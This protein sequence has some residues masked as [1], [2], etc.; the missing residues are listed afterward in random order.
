MS[1]TESTQT[2]DDVSYIVSSTYRTAVCGRLAEGAATPSTIA[3][4]TDLELAHASRAL[5][6][7]RG[8]GIVRLLVSDSRTKGRVYGMTDTGQHAHTLAEDQGMV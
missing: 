1:D 8:R 4:D 5:K 3:D 7:L 6:Q 2:W